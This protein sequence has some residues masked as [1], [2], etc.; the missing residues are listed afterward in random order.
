M[1]PE[2]DEW[3]SIFQQVPLSIY[4]RWMTQLRRLARVN[5]IA[6]EVFDSDDKFKTA[7]GPRV[8]TIEVLTILLENLEDKDLRQ[9]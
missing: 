3:R 2:P 8:L 7:I 4:D 1:T 5:G 6:V 9:S